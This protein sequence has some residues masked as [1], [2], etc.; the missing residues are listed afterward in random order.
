MRT[1]LM[2]WLLLAGCVLSALPGSSAAQRLDDHDPARVE[3]DARRLALSPIVEQGSEALL[4]LTVE[5]AP[6]SQLLARI[7]RIRSNTTLSPAARE[8]ILHSY[9]ERLRGLP[10]GSAPQPVLDWLAQAP[11]L[12]VTGHEEGPHHAVPLFNVAGAARGLVNEWSWRSGHDEVAGNAPLPLAT[13]AGRLGS[14]PLRSPRFRGARFA[15]GRLPTPALEALAAQCAMLPDGCGKARA[16][17][18]LA[19]GNVG[20]LRAWLAG[21]AVGEALPR[22]RR[23]RLFMSSSEAR[24]LMEAALEHPDTAVAAWAMSDL[25]AHPSTDETVRLEWG[26]RLVTLLDHPELGGAAALQL[27][28]MDPGDW[29]EAAASRPLGQRGRQRLELLAE[30]ENTLKASAAGSEVDR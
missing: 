13:L 15:I 16:D 24:E 30:M 23:T 10:P 27:A 17:I 1:A 5:G 18:E 22:L 8:A 21:A 25:T 20:W 2:S 4:K 26:G 14:M 28:R 19:R 12:A 29:L 7:E 3:P 9:V 6:A 11:P